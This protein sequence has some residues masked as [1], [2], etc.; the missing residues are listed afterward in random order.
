MTPGPKPMHPFRP[1]AAIALLLVLAACDNKASP[2][3]YARWTD[4]LI[5]EG[6]MRVDVDAPDLPYSD[7][8]LAEN[9]RRIALYHE[10]DAGKV[11]GPA[12][13]SAQPIHKWRTPVRYLLL[14]DG[15]TAEDRQIVERFGARVAAVTGLEIGRAER[16]ANLI[17]TI[18]TLGERAEFSEAM[19]RSGLAPLRESFDHWRRDPNWIC[20]GNA[21]TS[22]ERPNEIVGALIFL[23][24][25]VSGRLR[26]ACLHE[27][28]AQVLGLFNDDPEV[29]PS[30]FTDTSEF[31][32]LT[33]HDAELLSILYDPRLEP[34][35]DET[36]AML[37]V[38]EIIRD[39]RREKPRPGIGG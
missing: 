35:M 11:G 19:G 8:Q 1:L 29:R 39:M 36:E 25:G 14:G 13:R 4:A 21:L 15:V 18:T 22:L 3:A 33:V 27:E 37:L 38:P 2:E 16:D 26:E 5:A 12:N 20:G 24:A 28:F 9:F 34:G 23:D 10:V 30:L 6:L 32:R 31:A 7:D 17:I